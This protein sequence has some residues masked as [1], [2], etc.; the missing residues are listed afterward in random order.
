MRGHPAARP[1][2]A[3]SSRAAG[4]GEVGPRGRRVEPFPQPVLCDPRASPTLQTP[5]APQLPP[6]SSFF[7]CLKGLYFDK[8]NIHRKV[9]RTHRAACLPS[10][11]S[12]RRFAGATC[13]L[14]RGS[15]RPALSP[16][17]E[18]GPVLRR[19][20]ARPGC[21]DTRCAGCASCVA[22]V[23]QLPAR[24]QSHSLLWGQMSTGP[25]GCCEV[26]VS[27]ACV[28]LC[29]RTSH[30]FSSLASQASSL[31]GVRALSL[32]RSSAA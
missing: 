15:Q 13:L 21:R 14:L 26:S 4:P 17:A 29:T 1:S 3:G 9:Y 2:L 23:F 30:R 8:C 20:R 6:N 12:F 19:G 28:P 31:R 24:T 18:R 11:S 5:P 10:L 22:A 25:R 27:Q 16:A 7:I 32:A